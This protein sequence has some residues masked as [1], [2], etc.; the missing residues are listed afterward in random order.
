LTRRLLGA[1]A[2]ALALVGLGGCGGSEPSP[3]AELTVYVSA[4]N[5]GAGEQLVASAKAALADA[6]GEA[7]GVAVRG[8]YLDAPPDPAGVAANARRAV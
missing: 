6:G 4:P 5:T 7:G 8:V 3:D 1:A 2:V